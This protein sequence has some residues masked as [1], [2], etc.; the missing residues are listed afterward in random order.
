M[1]E[2]WKKSLDEKGIAGVVLMDLSKAFD[3]INHALLIA[4]LAA[5]GFDENALSVLFNYLSDRWQRTKINTSFSTWKELLQGVPQ[6]SILGPLLFNI[7]LNDL[8]FH[9][10]S[11]HVCNFADDTSL[12]A[13][14]KNIKELFH[15]LESDTLSTI[16]WFQDN[17]MKLN[18]DKCHFLISGNLHENLF[19]RVGP[20]LIWESAQQ[21]L[22]GVIIDKNLNFNKHLSTLCKKGS[23]KVTALARISKFLPFHKRKLLFNTFIQSQFSYCP[24][25]WMFC[26]RTMNNKI[27]NIHERA[28]RIKYKDYTSSFA[29][30]LNIDESVSIHHK[31]IHSVAIEMFK[32]KNDL[33]PSFFSELFQLNNNGPCTRQRNTFIRPKVN[34]VYKGDGSIRTFGPIVWNNLLPERIKQCTNLAE[35]KNLLKSWVPQNC[36]CRLCKEYIQCLGF[37]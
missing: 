35:F 14:N 10:N 32:V 27:N 5:Y 6:G 20:E 19:V 11:T 34:T 25:V 37:V 24:L 2:K 4:K 23:Q 28:L 30:L 9:I 21:K 17:Y 7:Y 31:N 22:L 12:N 3:T 8:L 16:A 15:D 36:P 13:F 1:I 29:H 26:S 18:N 33:C